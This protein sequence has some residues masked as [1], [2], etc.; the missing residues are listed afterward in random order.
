MEINPTDTASHEAMGLDQLM[1]L[2][3]F[4]LSNG[5]KF[6]QKIENGAPVAESSA[7]QLADYKGMT[8][9]FAGFEQPA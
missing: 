5:W 6:A 4:N 9:Y 2:E 8:A 1:H 7:R 3:I